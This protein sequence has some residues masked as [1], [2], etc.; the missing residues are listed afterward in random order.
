MTVA[1]NFNHLNL[2]KNLIGQLSNISLEYQYYKGG[3][4]P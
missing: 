1:R 4:E 2:E 3:T